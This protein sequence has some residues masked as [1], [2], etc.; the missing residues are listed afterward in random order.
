MIKIKVDNDIFPNIGEVNRRICPF[1]HWVACNIMDP[2]IIK[3]LSV[4]N[5]SSNQIPRVENLSARIKARLKN[6]KQRA[7]YL[8]FENLNF[9]FLNV[10]ED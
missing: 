1:W 5:Y 3:N 8:A 2:K 7:S 10:I 9:A 4:V 6:Y